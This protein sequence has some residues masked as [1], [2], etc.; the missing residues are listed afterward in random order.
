MTKP[1]TKPP[2]PGHSLPEVLAR[3]LAKIRGCLTSIKLAN[4]QLADKISP[5]QL[6][7]DRTHREAI[8]L[9]P[10]SMFPAEDEEG[11]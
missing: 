1:K 2:P 6:L 9:V 10:L 4:P 5:L 3:N 11:E 7:I 8:A